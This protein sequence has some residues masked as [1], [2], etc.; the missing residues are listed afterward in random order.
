[1]SILPSRRSRRIRPYVMAL[2]HQRGIEARRLQQ[3]ASVVALRD[4]EEV[5]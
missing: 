1:M 4:E 3:F 5:R 2:E